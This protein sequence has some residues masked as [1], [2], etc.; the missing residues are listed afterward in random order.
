M[1][2]KLAQALNLYDRIQQYK[3]RIMKKS[4]IITLIVLA[5]CVNVCST[6][7]FYQEA[8]RVVKEKLF[9]TSATSYSFTT[10][11]ISNNLTYN[12]LVEKVSQTIETVF[13]APKPPKAP[14]SCSCTT[15][16]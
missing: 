8:S 11:N 9:N 1:K 7:L 13:N 16:I 12:G 4:A 15:R 14:E 5:G 3:N 10:S 6:V 2:Y